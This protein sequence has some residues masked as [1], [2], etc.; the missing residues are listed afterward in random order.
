MYEMAGIVFHHVRARGKSRA[1]ITVR[2]KADPTDEPDEPTNP[3]PKP[4]TNTNHQP[5]TRNTVQ[6]LFCLPDDFALQSG[7]LHPRKSLFPKKIAGIALD[8]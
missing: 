3:V 8:V 6:P 2:L 7:Q 4:T 5:P 1:G